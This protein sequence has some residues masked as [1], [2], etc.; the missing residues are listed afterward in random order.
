MSN[1]YYSSKALSIKPKFNK[2]DCIV[3]IEGK[4][5][6][7]FWTYLFN[8]LDLDADITKVNGCNNLK[9]LIEKILI[10][11][12]KIIVCRDSDYTSFINTQKSHPRIIYTYGY[13]LENSLFCK[14]NLEDI[15]EICIK[16]K[17]INQDNLL[18]WLDQF[19]KKIKP[20]IIYEILN[21]KL[22]LGKKVIQDI[23]EITKSKNNPYLDDIKIKN[24]LEKF[25]VPDRKQNIEL[26][27]KSLNT[28]NKDL[29]Y[30]LKGHLLQRLILKFINYEAKKITGSRKSC[31]SENNLYNV[32]IGFVKNCKSNCPQYIY[33]K[34]KIN[35]ALS[36]IK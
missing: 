30:I 24:L 3:Y 25:D 5:D 26:I 33:Y 29:Y 9:P 34:D 18:E 21:L 20:I 12:A 27:E 19:E 31:I 23:T 11:D 7:L 4:D 8:R 13:S 15:I 2:A 35:S 32:S 14:K 10:E 1:F 17:Y 6:K 28:T 22:N 16:D 36:S